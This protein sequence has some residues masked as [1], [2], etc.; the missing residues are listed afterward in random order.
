MKLFILLE[1]VSGEPRRDEIFV[2]V[3]MADESML[4]DKYPS[5]F[6]FVRRPSG[7]WFL[8]YLYILPRSK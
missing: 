5:M 3:Y 8:Y 1:R 4:V 6:S 7:V 2:P